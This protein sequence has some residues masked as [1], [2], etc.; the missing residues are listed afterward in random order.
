MKVGRT[1]FLFFIFTV[2]SSSI[3]FFSN[4]YFA[5]ILGAGTLGQYFLVITVMTWASFLMGFGI[6]P[7]IKKRLSEG[8]SDAHVHAGIL[9]QLGMFVLLTVLLVTL[10]RYINSYVGMKVVEFLIIML[11]AKNVFNL[12]SAILEGKDLVHLSGALRPVDVISRNVLQVS[13]VFLGFGLTGML[14]GFAAGSFIA[15]V[16]GLWFV[17]LSW[18]RPSIAEVRS[19]VTYAKYAWING[20]RSRAF[21]WVDIAVLGFF[22]TP[23]LVGIYQIAWLIGMFFAMFGS[24]VGRSIFPVISDLSTDN[25]YKEIGELTT[26]SLSFS[27]L[28]LIPGLG[29]AV[30]VGDLVLS[31][32][33]SEFTRG[34][35]ILPILIL[36]HLLYTFQRQLTNALNAIDRPDLSFRVNAIFLVVNAVLSVL[37]VAYIGWLGAA[38]ASMLSTAVGTIVGYRA[39]SRIVD[40]SVVKSSMEISKQLLATAIM[41][42]TVYGLRTLLG[43]SLL[44][45]VVMI[46]VGGGVYFVVLTAASARFHRTV[47]RNLPAALQS[48]VPSR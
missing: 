38:I 29:G 44:A 39:L 2:I 16:V 32:Y 42:G 1:S 20:V 5:N 47:Y 12:L 43:E 45:L 3:G 21:S 14:V 7:A 6:N 22:V 46:G 23:N 36:A 24:A 19:L 33:G 9:L 40:I 27:G 37:I 10:E 25:A 31:I 30:V 18:K 8:K 17:A 34:T 11:F 4:I 26:K 41:C 35:T 48:Y 13:G 28:F 15:G